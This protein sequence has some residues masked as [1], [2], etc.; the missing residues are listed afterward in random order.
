MNGIDEGKYE[1]YDDVRLGTIS[2][3]RRRGIT[4]QALKEI[5]I[6]I[7]VTRADSTL[8]WD[9]LYTKN[10]RIIDERANRYFFVDKPKKVLIKGVPEKEEAKIRL[11]PDKTERGDRVIPLERE[12]DELTVWIS[13]TDVEKTEEKDVIRLKDLLN[14][15]LTSKNPL[16]AEFDSFG[17]MDVP[18]IQWISAD[19]VETEVLKPDGEYD[20]GLA[21][22]E[23]AKLEEGEV[24]QFERYG[25]VKIEEV[26]TKVKAVYTHS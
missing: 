25:F 17:L 24:I 11:H 14:F 15:K 6:D 2:A 3:L 9:T 26:G 12:N 10:R 8:S 4:P 18:K 23:V 13:G 5:I 22:P 20:E 16:E 21:E 1:G 19:P 7:G